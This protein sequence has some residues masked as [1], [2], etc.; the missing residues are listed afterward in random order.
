MK[1]WTLWTALTLAGAWLT[2]GREIENYVDHSRLQAA[3]KSVYASAYGRPATGGAFDHALHFYRGARSLVKDV[4]K[5]V[6]RLG[7]RKPS[8]STQSPATYPPRVEAQGYC[9]V[10]S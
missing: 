10:R 5:V 3:V 4:D 6:T 9:A 2:K 1:A 7:I 8:S